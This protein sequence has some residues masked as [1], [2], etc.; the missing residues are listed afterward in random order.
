MTLKQFPDGFIW[1]A[2]TAAYQIEG[3]WNE[4]GRGEST[5]DHFSHSPYRTINGDS[6]DVAC[7]HYHRW[8][9][10][11][12]MIKDLGIPNY[13][14]SISW[15]RILSTGQGSPNSKGL[16]FYNRLIDE[17]LKA[18]I[19]PN[20]TLN[21]WDLPQALEN[22]GGWVNRDTADRFV[23]YA[24]IMFKQLGDRVNLWS[25]HNEPF[26]IS[27][28]G[29]ALGIFPPGIADH[30]RAYQVSHH[31]LLSHAKA[32]KLYHQGGYKGQIGIVLNMDWLQPASNSQADLDARQRAFEN[33][34]GLYLD[35]IFKGHYPPG[36]FEWIGPMQP[37]IEPGDMELIKNSVDFL[38][39]NHYT[40]NRVAYSIG[41]MLK[42]NNT[43]LSAPGMG[44]TGTNWAINPIGLKNLL[45]ELKEKYNN[46][47]IIICENGCAMPD[48]VRRDG[49]IHDVR[50]VSYLRNYLSAAHEAI[51]AG[52]NLKGYFVWSLMD[53]F[54]WTSGYTKRFGI[55]HV[56]YGTQTRTPKKSAGWYSA[57]IARNGLLD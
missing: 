40:S 57:V 13:R 31:L 46:P 25:T 48:K 22:K 50:R 20:V 47:P 42:Y 1:G 36:L 29:F 34:S 52:V 33:N 12:R 5:W 3:A 21:H 53:N 9:E 56:D 28:F 45:L 6:G 41:S 26:I 4:D 14:L 15:P 44:V 17:L 10:D 16:D 19:Q 11:I 43:P 49:S 39:L 24:G 18:G 32:A 51:Q 54:E 37:H 38:G 7:D 55:V 8:A 23:D 35:P 2:A 27:Y 30:S